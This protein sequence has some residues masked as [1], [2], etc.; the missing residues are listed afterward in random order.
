VGIDSPGVGDTIVDGENGFL[1]TPDLAV[2]TAKLV[3][4]VMDPDVRRRL[5]EGARAS[6]QQYDINRTVALLLDQYVRLVANGA[7]RR[8]GFGGVLQRLRK[9]LS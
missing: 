5:A 3:R 8:H 6:A 7:R 4:L 2:F 1:S 9:R